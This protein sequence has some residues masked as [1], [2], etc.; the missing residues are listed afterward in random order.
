MA[1]VTPTSK[2]IAQG[3]ANMFRGLLDAVAV[4]CLQPVLTTNP[5]ETALTSKPYGPNDYRSGQ[6]AVQTDKGSFNF[7]TAP[8]TG[9][10]EKAFSNRGQYF[11][12]CKGDQKLGCTST[13]GQNNP[14]GDYII[15]G[16]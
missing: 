13:L 9:G 4:A 7:D 5:T 16:E 3:A 10:Y 11:M 1:F 12:G 2:G 6:R 8:Y 14:F 15:T